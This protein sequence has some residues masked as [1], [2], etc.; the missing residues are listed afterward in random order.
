MLAKKISP[1]RLQEKIKMLITRT[2]DKFTE[3]FREYILMRLKNH[4]GDSYHDK[5]VALLQRR[6]K[7]RE[8]GDNPELWD[9]TDLLTIF[10]KS[11]EP[12]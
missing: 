7:W 10:S 12:F 11:P 8:V 9:L 1:A 5:A 4:Y 3:R 6:I 2:I